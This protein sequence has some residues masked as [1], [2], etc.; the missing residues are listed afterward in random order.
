MSAPRKENKLT[1]ETAQSES[2]AERVANITAGEVASSLVSGAVGAAVG[3]VATPLVGAAAAVATGAALR[4]G[5]EFGGQ[6]VDAA[7]KAASDAAA[8]MSSAFGLSDGAVSTAV[9]DATREHVVVPTTAALGETAGVLKSAGHTLAGAG[10]GVSTATTEPSPETRA[11]AAE[12][13]KAAENTDIGMAAHKAVKVDSRAQEAFNKIQALLVAPGKTSEEKL[14]AILK[15]E[16][17]EDSSFKAFLGIAQ[18]ALRMDR[19]T[20]TYHGKTSDVSEFLTN[21]SEGF[22]KIFTPEAGKSREGGAEEMNA[23]FAVCGESMKVGIGTLPAMQEAIGTGF[24]SGFREAAKAAEAAREE[25]AKRAKA[26]SRTAGASEAAPT[27]APKEEL[28]LKEIGKDSLKI[29]GS[30]ALSLLVPGGFLIAMAACYI[31]R[32]KK[33]PSA[34]A[35]LPDIDASLPITVSSRSSKAPADP[36]AHSTTPTA[37][38]HA[39]PSAPAAIPSTTAASAAPATHSTPPPAASS[40]APSLAAAL[41]KATMDAV[42]AGKAAIAEATKQ[43]TPSRW[44]GR[45]KGEEGVPKKADEVAIP[46]D[47]D[48]KWKNNPMRRK[49][50]EAPPASPAAIVM[51]DVGGG[52][53]ASAAKEAAAAGVKSTLAG[54][55]VTEATAVGQG[56]SGAAITAKGAEAKGSIWDRI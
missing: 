34:E 55:E 49:S 20:E 27:K 12:V 2:L 3:M 26:E 30:I 31:L 14:T 22:A 18:A 28:S 52:D 44:F 50:A 47:E 7:S 25:E 29:A 13:V 56:G 4:V 8:A 42:E 5:S 15:M 24:E 53:I 1:T 33:T 46:K 19:D 39:I 37:A 21:L 10:A 9:G 43:P 45:G 11:A 35:G 6:I 48:L 41:D 17:I 23:A 40:T 38:S 32:D 54:L 51:S 36:A 16:V